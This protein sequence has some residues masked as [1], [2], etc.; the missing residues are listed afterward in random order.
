MKAI[1]WCAVAAAVLGCGAGRGAAT[2]FDGARAFTYLQAQVANGPRIPNTDAHRRA[3]DF[4]LAHLKQTADS[5]EVQAWDHVTTRHDTLH[6]RNFIARFRPAAKERVLYLTHWDSRPH[7]DQSANLAD[8]QR[9]VLGANDGASGVALLLGVADALHQLPPGVGVDLLFVDGEDYGDF[10]AAPADVLIG[11]RFFAK[12]L[13]PDQHPLYAVLF[14]MIGDKDLQ[15]YQEANS[16][17][18]AP[19]IVERVWNKAKDLGYARFFRPTV[20]HQ[21]V[22]DHQSLLDVGVH[23]IDVVDF[24]YGENNSYWH[25][26]QDTIDKVSAQSLQ[27]VGDVAV[28]LVR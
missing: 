6:L 8:Q 5:V 10:E 19:E 28:A 26:L 18:Y 20:G 9:P 1:S 14:D 7:A 3:G 22:D 21:L 2:N 27:I 12:A 17:R 16:A 24:D 25:T 11:S 15:I 13:K 23:T 4:I